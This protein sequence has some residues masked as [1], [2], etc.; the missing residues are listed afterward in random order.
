MFPACGEGKLENTPPEPEGLM[1]VVGPPTRSPHQVPG[2]FFVPGPGEKKKKRKNFFFGKRG[3]NLHVMG[4]EPMT[5]R[6]E[7]A[8]LTTR[9]TGSLF[10]KWLHLIVLRINFEFLMGAT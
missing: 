4:F 6:L 10:E 2:K 9:S 3:K 7:P 1:L 5:S 8:S